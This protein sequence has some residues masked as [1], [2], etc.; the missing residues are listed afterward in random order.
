LL[1]RRTLASSTSNLPPINSLAPPLCYPFAPSR[2][3]W[4]DATTFLAEHL[5]T[6]ELPRTIPTPSVSKSPS[7]FSYLIYLLLAHLVTPLFA[8]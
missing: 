5:Q 1:P 7:S 6:C 8:F 4:L 3:R 2:D